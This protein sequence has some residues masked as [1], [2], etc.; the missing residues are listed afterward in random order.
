MYGRKKEKITKVLL[1][2]VLILISLVIVIPLL[3]MLLGAFKNSAEVTAFD[4][5]LPEQWLVENFKTVF[6]QGKLLLAF[7]NSILITIASTVI[8]IF[9]SSLASFILARRK[10][11][12]SRFLYYFFFIGTIIPM[13]IMPTIRLFTVLD[14]YGGY[15]N[16]IILYTAINIPFSCFLYTGFIR[17][18]PGVL[19]ESAFIEG[20]STLQTYFY[21]ILPLLKSCNITVLIL[22]FTGIW[23]EINI[24]LYFLNDPAKRTLPLSVYQ[25]FGMYGGSNWN[26]VFA[27]LTLAALP[28]ILLFLFMQKQFIS[29]LTEGAVKG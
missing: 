24:P 27:D 16:V 10:T 11:R 12:F 25:F 28:V 22:L 4:L 3:I 20:A 29:G 17:G 2:I 19:D 5:T 13:Q 7:K 14:I 9:T 23:N 6:E 21:I 15:L 8:T 26:L 18:I 1:Q